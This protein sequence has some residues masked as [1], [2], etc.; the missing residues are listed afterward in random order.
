MIIWRS[1]R[2]W[3]YHYFIVT[4]IW[5]NYFSLLDTNTYVDEYGNNANMFT[6]KPADAAWEFSVPFNAIDE[7]C[8]ELIMHIYWT[9]TK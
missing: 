9:P 4:D 5:D 8:G 2:K 7:I 3:S 6:W 1:H